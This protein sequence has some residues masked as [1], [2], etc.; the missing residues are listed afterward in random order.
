VGFIFVPLQKIKTTSAILVLLAARQSL[1]GGAL[2]P[3]FWQEGRQGDPIGACYHRR[4][5]TRT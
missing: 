5:T 1:A 2:E 3:F 4:R